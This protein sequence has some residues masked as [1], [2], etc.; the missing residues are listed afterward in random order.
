[1]ASD[2]T[3]LHDFLE[4]CGPEVSGRALPSPSPELAELLERFV[5]GQCSADDRSA[6][7]ELLQRQPEYLREL[8]RRVMELRERGQT[9]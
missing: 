7:C 6:V 9:A 1:M 4:R 8:A 5:R 2:F 3:I